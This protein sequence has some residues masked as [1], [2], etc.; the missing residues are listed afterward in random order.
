[1]TDATSDRKAHFSFATTV[2]PDGNDGAQAMDSDP[3]HARRKCLITL[4]SELSWADRTTKGFL[5]ALTETSL[6]VEM[7]DTVIGQP[8]PR[9]EAVLLEGSC[10]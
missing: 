7:F 8:R 10:L 5:I 9:V 4:Q 2:D 1:M 3:T 6:S